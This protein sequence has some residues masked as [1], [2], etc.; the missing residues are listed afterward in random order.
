MVACDLAFRAMALFRLGQV[1]DARAALAAAEAEMSQNPLSGNDEEN[2]TFVAEARAV[3]G[4][5]R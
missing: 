5:S 2:R 4:G 3:L 1:A